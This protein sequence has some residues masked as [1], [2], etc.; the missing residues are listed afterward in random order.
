[1]KTKFVKK[2]GGT[3]LFSFFVAVLF[4][5]PRRASLPRPYFYG[6]YVGK[7]A[8]ESHDRR[9]ELMPA[10]A[11]AR[12]RNSKRECAARFDRRAGLPCSDEQKKTRL[13]SHLSA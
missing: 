5:A 9:D 8:Q 12:F 13:R 3:G 6:R 10:I 2:P 1:L 7:R 4:C 11:R